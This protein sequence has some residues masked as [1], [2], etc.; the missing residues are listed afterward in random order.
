MVKG[1]KCITI[2]KP[3]KVCACAS[4]SEFIDALLVSRREV[5]DLKGCSSIHTSSSSIINPATILFN[6]SNC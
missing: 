6:E 1:G 5:S 3:G 4:L 2:N